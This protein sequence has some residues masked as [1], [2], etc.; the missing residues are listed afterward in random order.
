[1]RAY[2]DQAYVPHPRPE[3]VPVRWRI[4][5]YA[6]VEREG[7]ILMVDQHVATGPGLTLPG[8]G[9]EVEREETIL[10]GSVREVYEET[11][12]R[13]APEPASLALI[14]DH[15]I[16]SPSGRYYHA[17]S[18]VVRGTVGE[19]PDPAWRR[20]PGEIIAVRWADPADLG[21]DTVRRLHWDLLARLGLVAERGGAP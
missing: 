15:F 11:G 3:N 14:D 1:V 13:F 7:R 6:L 20:D 19:R 17:L 4:G 9:V 21:P 10:E 8:G 5:V 16:R 12:Y 18:F 2:I